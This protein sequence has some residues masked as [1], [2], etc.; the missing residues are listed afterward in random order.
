MIRVTK[1]YL[2]TGLQDNGLRYTFLATS[3]RHG[4]RIKTHLV[5]HLRFVRSS[6]DI[7][8]VEVPSHKR[9]FIEFFNKEMTLNATVALQ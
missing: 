4:G 5:R 6:I 2:V 1:V 7:K 8:K 3:K 9:E